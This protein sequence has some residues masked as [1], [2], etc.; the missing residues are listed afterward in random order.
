[1][2]VYKEVEFQEFIKAIKQ[3]AISH[4]QE[5]AE[6]LD[7]EPDTITRWKETPEAV[8]ARR[9]GI[10]YALEQM[11]QAGKKDWRMWQ[12]KLKMLGINP[13][14]KV[15]AEMRDSRKEI[16]GKY[17]LGEEGA[18]EATQAESRPPANSA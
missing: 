1:M 18:G 10:A 5:I 16:L 4:W 15:Q 12:E 9:T 7:V 14:Q 17:G 3:G 11:E 6:A 2:G 13:P 8:E